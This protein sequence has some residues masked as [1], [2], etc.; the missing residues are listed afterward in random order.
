MNTKVLA[1]ML[2]VG[3]MV[4]GVMA[5]MPGAEAKTRNGTQPTSEKNVLYV[6]CDADINTW[7]SNTKEETDR[8]SD[9]FGYGLIFP[10]AP[11]PFLEYSWNFPLE[12]VPESLILLESGKAIEMTAYMT[13]DDVTLDVTISCE[14]TCDGTSIA[15]GEAQD[16]SFPISSPTEVKWSVV[17][18]VTEIPAGSNLTWIVSFSST[19]ANRIGL[20]CSGDAWTN[21]VLPIVATAVSESNETGAAT[22]NQTYGTSGGSSGTGSGSA[23]GGND[24][25][26]SSDGAAGDGAT[27]DQ[28]ASDGTAAASKTP[29]FEMFVLIGAIGVAMFLLRRKK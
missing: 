4:G 23:S 18:Q 5:V 24:Q 17:P 6:H 13:A 14:L 16:F 26:V 21:L 9:G 20:S 10:V 3:M 12:P 15:S 27:G 22:G 8:A 1:A 29:G 2:M 11:S 28:T 25:P 19:A 7:M